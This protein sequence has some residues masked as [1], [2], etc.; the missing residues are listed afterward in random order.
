MLFAATTRAMLDAK[1]MSFFAE[2]YEQD[3]ALLAH[4]A[5]LTLL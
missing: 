4:L 3:D 5:W 1:Q 2:K